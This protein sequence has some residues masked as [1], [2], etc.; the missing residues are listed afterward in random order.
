[1]LAIR[2]HTSSPFEYSRSFRGSRVDGGMVVGAPCPLFLL[3]LP[4][5]KRTRG[6]R[7]RKKQ[8]E[9]STKKMEEDIKPLLLRRRRPRVDRGGE[10]RAM[11]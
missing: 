11:G 5:P 7:I 10:T 9:G 2:S 4:F 1:M 8:E 6:M 3:F